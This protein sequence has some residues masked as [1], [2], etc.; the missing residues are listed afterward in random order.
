LTAVPLIIAALS[1]VSS[2]YSQIAIES[3][4]NMPRSGS[5]ITGVWPA[6][7][8]SRN[9]SRRSH[10]DS[11]TSSQPTPFSPSRIRTLREKGQSGN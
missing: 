5:V 2:K 7:V 11:R 8:M 4:S 10:G 1:T 3:I 9:S 6:G